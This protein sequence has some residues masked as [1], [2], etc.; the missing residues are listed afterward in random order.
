MF[1]VIVLFV[2]ATADRL[3]KVIALTFHHNTSLIGE[4]LLFQSSA[5]PGGLLGAPIP[6]TLLLTLTVVIGCTFVFLALRARE[7]NEQLA[8]GFVALGVASNGYDRIAYAYVIDVFRFFSLSFNLAD[9]YIIAG[10]LLVGWNLFAR[11][12]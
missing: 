3:T 7:T 11:R 2:F 12:A 9:L 8:F 10:V 6:R 1:A 4:V 5:N